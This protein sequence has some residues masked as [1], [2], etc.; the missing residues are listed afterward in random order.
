MKVVFTDSSRDL[1]E[2]G[3]YN[4]ESEAPATKRPFSAKERSISQGRIDSER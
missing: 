1:D 2:E 3:Y 4:G